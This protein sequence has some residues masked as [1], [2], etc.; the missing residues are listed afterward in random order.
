[1]GGGGD[2]GSCPPSRVRV[3]YRWIFSLTRIKIRTVLVGFGSGNGRTR[4]G[5]YIVKIIFLIFGGAERK[6]KFYI[7][8]GNRGRGIR[9]VYK[10]ITVV[11]FY[12]DRGRVFRFPLLY[13]TEITR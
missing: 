11:I 3:F 8:K 4:D 6:E 5:G 9:P 7:Y 2:E 10:I 13:A 12:D 1:M